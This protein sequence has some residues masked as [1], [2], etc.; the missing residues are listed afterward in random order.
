M[1]VD[2]DKNIKEIENLTVR[3]LWISFGAAAGLSRY[4]VGI[5]NFMGAVAVDGIKGIVFLSGIR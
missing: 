1:L 5:L 2:S 3:V 4:S